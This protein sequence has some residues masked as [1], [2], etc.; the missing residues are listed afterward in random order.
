MS[1]AEMKID[2]IV[3]MMT[4][5]MILGRDMKNLEDCAMLFYM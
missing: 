2:K 3:T 1:G 4:A 5:L